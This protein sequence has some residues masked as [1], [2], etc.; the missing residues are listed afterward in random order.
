MGWT[1]DAIS[2]EGRAIQNLLYLVAA[3]AKF[4]SEVS[5]ATAALALPF[6]HQEADDTA[7]TTATRPR[8]IAVEDVYDIEDTENHNDRSSGEILLS[9]E[10]PVGA[11]DLGKPADEK[12][13]FLN[14]VETIVAQMR[15]LSG[16]GTGYFAGCTHFC[17]GDIKRDGPVFTDSD[18]PGSGASTGRQTFI[19]VAYR[20]R[21][22]SVPA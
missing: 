17:I 21:Y 7:D 6:C 12:A 15:V 16:T 2:D 22:R 11:G 1:V 10:W 8:V 3:T 18:T 9:F 4:R 19:A 13:R 20:V 14:V 5:V